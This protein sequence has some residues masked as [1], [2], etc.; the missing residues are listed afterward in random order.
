MKGDVISPCPLIG[1]CRV[2]ENNAIVITQ[3]VTVSE[4][5][6]S[7]CP[8]LSFQEKLDMATTP[9]PTLLAVLLH[10]GKQDLFATHTV[11]MMTVASSDYQ[12]S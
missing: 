8:E 1:W 5:C 11:A 10:L 9:L 4:K 3:Q 7:R 2:A 6:S 12:Y